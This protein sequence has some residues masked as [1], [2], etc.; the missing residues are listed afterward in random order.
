MLSA[1]PIPI[2][3]IDH[4]ILNEKQVQLAVLRIDQVHEEVSGNKFFKLKYNLEE[5]KKQGKTT[6]LSFG[7]AF[8]NHI[9][10]LSAAAKITG[11]KSTGI[12]RGEESSNTNP[13]LS[14]AVENGMKLHFVSREEYRRKTEPEF[15]AALKKKL[16]DF[17]LIPEGGTNAFAIQGTREI[18]GLTQGSFSHIAVSIG[19][20]GTFAGIAASMEEGQVLLGF[21]A[22]KGAWI[23]EEI[24]QLLHTEGIVP[25]GHYQVMEEY[26]F[27]GYAKWKPELIDFIRWFWREFQIPLDPIYTGKMAFGLWDII[28]SGFFP[29]KSV[30]LMIHTGGLQ[31]IEGFTAMTG[32]VFPQLF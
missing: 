16:G 7:G 10:A 15:I 14:K 18:L 11:L 31:G 9:Q 3:P 12:I 6:V 8:S 2:Q 5:A 22:L 29:A 13:T 32:E 28:E 17:Y 26:H 24:N 23:N 19:T 30:I 25:R 20:G 21:P 4:P 27:G 1:N